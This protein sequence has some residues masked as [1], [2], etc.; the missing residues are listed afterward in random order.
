MIADLPCPLPGFG[1]RHFC[2]AVIIIIKSSD[3]RT[4]KPEPWC[5]LWGEMVDSLLKCPLDQVVAPVSLLTNELVRELPPP[6]PPP[7]STTPTTPFPVSPMLAPQ[8][9]TTPNHTT[10]PPPTI[11]LTT[12]YKEIGEG[13]P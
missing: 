7:T 10:Y 1:C 13:S 5:N 8:E 9:S 12:N 11:T 4:R 6:P 3:I 2:Q